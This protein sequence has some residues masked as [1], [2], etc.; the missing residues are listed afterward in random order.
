MTNITTMARTSSK[1]TFLERAKKAKAAASKKRSKTARSA[2]VAK[3]RVAPVVRSTI[4]SM[5]ETKYRAL[6]P[7]KEVSPVAI[8]TAGNAS[9]RGVCLGKAP[10]N[11]PS[12]A[13]GMTICNGFT[14][15]QGDQKGQR[16]GKKVYLRKT[17]FTTNIDMN[18]TT[19]TGGPLEFRVILAKP[20]KSGAAAGATY[21]PQTSL[22][23]DSS[24]DL[25]GHTQSG[26]KGFDLMCQPL[27]KKHWYVRKD[28]KFKLSHPLA[29]A[30]PSGTGIANGYSGNYPTSKTFRLAVN[31]N[32]QV[33]FEDPNS[34]DTPSDANLGWALYIYCKGQGQDQTTAAKWELNVR[35]TTS[36][37]DM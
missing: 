14:I 9:W 32:K 26:I 35:G 23:L 8:Q 1:S 37:L 6:D 30:N 12:S 24:N 11:W 33:S 29:Q 31:H 22:F 10:S 18:Q 28:F 15:A 21:T 7:L 3:K 36:Y 20:R 13:E 25:F 27:A 16:D 5:A 17:T 4:R 2:A 19:L 34:P